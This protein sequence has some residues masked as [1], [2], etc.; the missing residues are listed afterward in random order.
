M[1]YPYIGEGI[2]SGRIVN[3]TSPGTGVIVK[4]PTGCHKIGY[5]SYGWAEDMFIK[6]RQKILIGGEIL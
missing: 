4:D 1:K 6:V 2:V 5:T 3:F